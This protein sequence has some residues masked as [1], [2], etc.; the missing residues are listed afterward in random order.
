MRLEPVKLSQKTALSD[1]LRYYMGKNTQQRQQFIIENLRG[2]Q[3]LMDVD[4]GEL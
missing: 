3:P 2:E 4:G 1:L